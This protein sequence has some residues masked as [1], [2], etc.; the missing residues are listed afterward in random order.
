M[1]NIK[2]SILTKYITALSQELGV[3]EEKLNTILDNTIQKEIKICGVVK[4]NGEVCKISPRKWEKCSGHTSKWEKDAKTKKNEVKDIKEDIKEEIKDDKKIQCS[5]IYTISPRVGERCLKTVYKNRGTNLCYTHTYQKKNSPKIEE[6]K[7]IIGLRPLDLNFL[8]RSAALEIVEIEDVEPLSEVKN[9]ENT[10]LQGGD[11]PVAEEKEETHHRIELREEEEVK[12]TPRRRL[13]RIFREAGLAQEAGEVKEIKEDMQYYHIL[14][15]H[16]SMLEIFNNPHLDECPCPEHSNDTTDNL[17]YTDLRQVYPELSASTMISSLGVLS[18]IDGIIQYDMQDLC[19]LLTK[20]S[21]IHYL[22]IVILNH[23]K[24][25]RMKMFKKT[26]DADYIGI[27]HD[28]MDYFKESFQHL[29]PQERFE[30]VKHGFN[31]V[32]LTMMNYERIPT[33]DSEDVK[34]YLSKKHQNSWDNV[35]NLTPLYM[36]LMDMVKTYFSKSHVYIPSIGG[37][38]SFYNTEDSTLDDYLLNFLENLISNLSGHCEELYV[39]HSQNMSPN[40]PEMIM[41]LRNIESLTR[42]D[43]LIR[44]LMDYFKKVEYILKETDT[45]KPRK[46]SLVEQGELTDLLDAEYDEEWDSVKKYLFRE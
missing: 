19:I 5:H 35:R 28:H 43:R 8:P 4:K 33:L 7:P 37:D 29:K 17:L 39:R 32:E 20:K 34:W 41:L 24:N 3:T 31:T 36:S 14:N 23:L 18:I 15:K 27:L 1:K 45:Y 12:E 46:K 26:S 40:R 6:T 44:S 9:V 13:E 25:K 11:T 22:P 10:T 21:K 16:Q 30:M 38:W 42:K 2:Y